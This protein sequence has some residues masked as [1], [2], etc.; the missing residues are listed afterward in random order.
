MS[1]LSPVGP[2]H[3]FEQEI[4][5]QPR[6]PIIERAFALASSGS[7]QSIKDIRAKLK[8]E[9]YFRVEEFIDGKQLFAKLKK[10]CQDSTAA[11]TAASTDG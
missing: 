7:C 6:M 4:S 5:M 11:P 9:G 2:S 3:R 1:C 8:A 10:I